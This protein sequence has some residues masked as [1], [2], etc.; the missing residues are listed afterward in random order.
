MIRHVKISRLWGQYEVDWQPHPDVNILVGINGSGKSALLQVI[1]AG[2]AHKT[3]EGL[4]YLDRALSA[5]NDISPCYAIR[6]EGDGIDVDIKTDVKEEGG[7]GAG[8]TEL[9]NSK[10][11]CEYDLVSTFDNIASE[12]K[13]LEQKLSP[14]AAQLDAVIF[15]TQRRS[16]NSYRLKA[17]E[18][19]GTGI[20]ISKQ[21]MKWIK[22]VN[23]FFAVTGK[24]LE[25]QGS[26]IS[27]RQAD[28]TTV[29]LDQL[30]AGEK[31][32]MIILISALV[33]DGSPFILLLDEPEISLDIDWQYKLIET[34]RTLNPRCQLII[35]THSPAVFG[36]GWSDKLFFTE[37]LLT[38]S[39]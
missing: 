9:N 26:N 3:D 37:D 34:I 31:Q 8:H 30:S 4:S 25:M 36:D 18:D 29:V 17:T 16:L 27:F 11:E 28:G 14:L 23:S 1:R 35:A 20:R 10:V 7:R 5:D 19:P 13:A 33:Q 22:V 24:T 39:A 38:K 6:I 2:L 15:D 21:L 12:K 32:L